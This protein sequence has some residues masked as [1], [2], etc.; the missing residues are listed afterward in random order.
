MTVIQVQANHCAGLAYSS[1]VLPNSYSFKQT[2][3]QPRIESYV[4]EHRGEE[5]GGGPLP[6]TLKH[7]PCPCTMRAVAQ[8]MGSVHLS[9]RIAVLFSFALFPAMWLANALCPY[10]EKMHLES[11]L[12]LRFSPPHSIGLLRCT[13]TMMC[14]RALLCMVDNPYHVIF[15]CV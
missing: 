14:R 4:A 13:P 2:K 10:C 12:S 1:G 5:R 15:A 8:K 3:R 7:P 9:T 6:H 11:H